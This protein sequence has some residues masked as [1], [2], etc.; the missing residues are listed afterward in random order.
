M[1]QP[2]REP[3]DVEWK[4]QLPVNDRL[5]GNFCGDSAFVDLAGGGRDQGNLATALPKSGE[6]CER[7][8]FLPAPAGRGLGVDN[9]P[10]PLQLF[11]HVGAP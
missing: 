4:I 3:D 11:N 5:N 1:A 10:A 2:L 9:A 8:M 7:A 6:F